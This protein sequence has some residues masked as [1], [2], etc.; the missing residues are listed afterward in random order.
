MSTISAAQRI[1]TL[2]D[3]F[4]EI[5]PKGTSSDPIR[6]PGYAAEIRKAK[7]AG[8]RESV[9]IGRAT[10]DGYEAIAAV[11]DFEF[12]GGSMGEVAGARL[13]SA[14]RTAKR[15]KLP[16]VVVVRSGGARMQE[17]MA[18]LAQM[19]RTVA[20]SFALGDR[21]IPRISILANPTTG[22]VYASFASLADFVIAEKDATIGFAGPRVA[23]AFMGQALPEGSHTAWAA[24]DAGQ[25]DRVLEPAKVRES[26]RD[27]LSLLKPAPTLP[28]A[29]VTPRVQM[30][31]GPMAAWDS[32]QLVRQK[33]RPSPRWYV[34]RLCSEIWELHGDRTGADD[35][36]V[37]CSL[38]RFS[39]LTIAFI[40]LDRASPTA[41]GYRK[42]QR[43]IDIA[44]RLGMPI[45][46]LVDT[47]GADPSY[48]SEYSGLAREIAR[49]FEA[50]LKARV[51]VIT[52]VT[53]EGGS[54][55]ALALACGDVI[56]IQQ[57][58]VF[59][60]IAPEGAASILHRDT[61]RAQEVAELLHPR[62][63]DL[64]SLGLADHLIP[65]PGRGAHQDPDAAAAFLSEWLE[66]AMNDVVASP[67]S[68]V[69]R[70]R[71]VRRLFD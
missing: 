70:Y 16:F 44:S 19:P 48:Q 63:D 29:P 58:A 25:V 4:L 27:L 67:R 32:Y 54:G 14:M 59:S 39:E 30:L 31:S 37:M 41:G 9:I 33:G 56:G 69:A 3:Q 42:A 35:N 20:A 64:V 62:A 18:A 60:V 47:R 51:P 23:E 7:E 46:T 66:N 38:G 68:R 11:F 17:G 8:A 45:V 52:A 34:E 13:E 10:M 5:G 26:L 55:G 71:K 43:M 21:G 61:S 12:M 53:G 65:E 57:G 15:T 2:F 49:T 40:A 50:L 22:G 1:E 24:F 6:F 28:M 36:A